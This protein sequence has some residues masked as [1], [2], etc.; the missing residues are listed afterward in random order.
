MVG[1]GG[2]WEGTGFMHPVS[3]F[4]GVGEVDVVV[5]GLGFWG[6]A[7]AKGV[8]EGAKRREGKAKQRYRVGRDF[9]VWSNLLEKAGFCVEMVVFQWTILGKI[10]NLLGVTT[11]ES[12]RSG[13]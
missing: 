4:L 1:E 3:W 7:K 12:V 5:L 13:K 9:W 10:V 6:K 2:K 8:R 11:I